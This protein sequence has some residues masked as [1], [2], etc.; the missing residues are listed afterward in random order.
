[1]IFVSAVGIYCKKKNFA[2]VRMKFY[3]SAAVDWL[4][5][6]IEN[7]YS[8]LCALILSFIISHCLLYNTKQSLVIIRIP[9]TI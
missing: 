3:C 5:L 8:S 2:K 4:H 9:A 1:M 6:V 7:I